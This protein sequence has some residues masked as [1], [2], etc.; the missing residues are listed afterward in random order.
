MTEKGLADARS[1]EV[2]RHP[3][4]SPADPVGIGAG[5]GIWTGW[6]GTG[7][8]GAG[9]WGNGSRTRLLTALQPPLLIYS[10]VTP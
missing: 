8:V 4:M 10:R 1:S 6:V 9:F 3:W 7:W 5:A 2:P